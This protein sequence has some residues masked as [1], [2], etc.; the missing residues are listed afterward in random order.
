MDYEAYGKEIAEYVKAAE[1]KSKAAFGDAV[2]IL[3]RCS[4]SAARLEKAG[5]AVL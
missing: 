3:R 2:A 1:L 4:S 5:A